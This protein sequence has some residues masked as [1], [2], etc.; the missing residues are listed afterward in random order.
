MLLLGLITRTNTIKY[1]VGISPAGAGTFLSHG[2]GGQISD[3][4]LPIQSGFLDMLTFWDSVLAVRGFLI[5]R[6]GGN[7]GDCPCNAIFNSSK[8]TN[9]D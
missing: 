3:K 8:I 5:A 7:K 6:R 1:L 2:W 9:A 4:Q